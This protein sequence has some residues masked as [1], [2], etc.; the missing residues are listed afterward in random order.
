MKRVAC[1]ILGFPSAVLHPGALTDFKEEL[2]AAIAEKARIPKEEV[3]IFGIEEQP[4]AEEGGIYCKVD[5]FGLLSGKSGQ[6]L[7]FWIE[8][9]L[10][11]ATKM[12]RD[13]FIIEVR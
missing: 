3:M 6:L 1:Q 12:H 8:A 13:D 2:R 11:G 7:K 9:Q 10:E 4:P 5:S